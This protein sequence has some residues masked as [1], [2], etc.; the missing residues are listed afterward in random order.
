MG[1]IDLV[2]A[3]TNDASTAQR[4]TLFGDNHQPATYSDDV[5]RELLAKLK[6]RAQDRLLQTIDITKL[7]SAGYDA[8]FGEIS[9]AVNSL[10]HE[11]NLRLTDAD[12]ARLIEV[13]TNEMVGLGPL[14]PLLQDN[15]V[16]DILVN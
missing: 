6:H 16:S 1:L 9:S 2:Q 7:E 5:S 14:E 4:R 12:R 15:S 10:I 3:S 8:L 13:T 11:D